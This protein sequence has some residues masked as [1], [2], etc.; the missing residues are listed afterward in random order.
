MTSPPSNT[1]PSQP[2]PDPPD[3]SSS[4]PVDCT[5]QFDRC[6]QHWHVRFADSSTSN[7]CW[8]PGWI[9]FEGSVLSLISS[10]GVVIASRVIG[11]HDRL[12]FGG[13]IQIGERK[14][15]VGLSCSDSVRRRVSKPIR[16]CDVVR[17][18]PAVGQFGSSMADL[19]MGCTI[20]G[21][22]H[23]FSC[24]DQIQRPSFSPR[25]CFSAARSNPR[26]ERRCGI[27]FVRPDPSPITHRSPSPVEPRI[28]CGVRSGDRRSFAQV[29]SVPRP[30]DRR[31]GNQRRSPPHRSPS[32]NYFSNRPRPGSDADRR[33]EMRRWEDERRREEQW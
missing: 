27:V 33:E 25:N 12:V 9:A 28:W 5:A 7:P 20:L 22:V 6:R 3:P 1:A 13:C 21:P 24:P 26:S 23:A 17:T 30:M 8:A 14:I 16:S 10:V 31:Y 2:L 4:F 15:K 19:Q 11:P 18:R 29:V 32:R